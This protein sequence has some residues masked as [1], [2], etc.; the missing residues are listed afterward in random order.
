MSA[1][2]VRHR[3][4]TPGGTPVAARSVTAELIT[5]APLLADGSGSIV[6]AAADASDNNGWVDLPLVP[7]AELAAIGS[8]YRVTV[9][10][11][12]I[13]YY[14]V[15]PAGATPVLLADI[16]VDPASLEPLPPQ[17]ATLYLARAELGLPGGPVPLAGDGKIDG[18]Y[19]PAGSGGAAVDSVNGHTGVVVLGAADVG[20]VPTTRQIAT[21]AGLTGGGPLTANLTIALTTAA[22]AS[23]ARADTAVLPGQLAAVAT[24]GSYGDL[25]GQVPT[26]ALPSL[27][28][29]EYLGDVGSQAAMLALTGELGDWCTRSDLGTVW[30]ITGPNPTQL[31]SWTAFTY[32]AAPVVSVNGQSGV[33][34]LSKAD[35]GL[36]QVANLSPA[37]LPV[38]SAQ[39][40]VIDGRGVQAFASSGRHQ[41]ALIGDTSSAW[42]LSPVQY[43]AP[44]AAAPGDVLRWSAH[45]QINA[46]G[47]DAELD[48]VSVVDGAAARYWSTGTTVAGPNG[49]GQ[50]YLGPGY[51]RALPTIDWPVTSDDIDDDGLVTLALRYRQSGSGATIGSTLYPGHVDVTNL[52]GPPA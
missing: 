27:A 39:A 43:R 23:L 41:I 7:Q 44:I 45:L 9:A 14:C 5:T 31:S 10:D 33:V 46:G 12:W 15:V 52:G 11:T 36:D 51:G 20:A 3:L 40:A 42:T 37:N 19:L 25:V 21:G 18:R 38:S 13:T 1:V 24:S 48:I 35:I 2:T 8:H 49:H 16:L 6:V 29:V 22:V 4:V 34:V 47:A 30:I 26:S 50:L 17:A 28:V 32:P